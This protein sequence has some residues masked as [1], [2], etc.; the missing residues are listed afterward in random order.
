L[1]EKSSPQGK[2]FFPL[3]LSFPPFKFFFVFFCASHFGHCYPASR[4]KQLRRQGGPFFLS[5]FAHPPLG[6]LFFFF[7][8]RFFFFSPTALY[9][10]ERA[11]AAFF[12]LPFVVFLFYVSPIGRAFFRQ[13]FFLPPMSFRGSAILFEAPHSEFPG[14]RIFVCRAVFCFPPLAL[15]GPG[16]PPTKKRAGKD[17]QFNYEIEA[18][19][20]TKV[21]PP[22]S[23]FSFFLSGFGQKPPSP[24]TSNKTTPRTILERFFLPAFPLLQFWPVFPPL[25]QSPGSMPTMFNLFF[26]VPRPPN[27]PPGRLFWK[28]N[29]FPPLLRPDPI[30]FSPISRVFFFLWT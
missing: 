5:P 14:R 18:F 19:L 6:P 15:L 12:F 21:P 29:T 3:D 4:S 28:G 8:L 9:G 23:L 2:F 30:F 17:H 10:I 16:G 24:L 20:E 26:W 22:S 13:F 1:H 25:R 7:L 11:P 27:G